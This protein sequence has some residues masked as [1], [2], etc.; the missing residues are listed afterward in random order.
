MTQR[1]NAMTGLWETVPPEPVPHQGYLS[2]PVCG[3]GRYTTLKGYE[4][5]YGKEHGHAAP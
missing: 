3:K 4:D 2:C 1:F 5:H